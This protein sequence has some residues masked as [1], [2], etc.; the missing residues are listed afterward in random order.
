MSV[1][2]DEVR[3]GLANDPDFSSEEDLDT[4]TPLLQRLIEVVTKLGFMEE[5]VTP[6]GICLVHAELIEFMIDHYKLGSDEN[7]EAHE[8]MV[9]DLL[10]G[11][12][13]LRDFA[14]QRTELIGSLTDEEIFAAEGSPLNAAAFALFKQKRLRYGD[15]LRISVRGLIP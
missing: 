8:R 7:Q 1:T 5:L 11:V 6:E 10:E 2:L 9:T 14:S 3:S 4:I 13:Q 15:L 12:H